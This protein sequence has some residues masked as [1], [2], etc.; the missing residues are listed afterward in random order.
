ME[1]NETYKKVCETVE[2]FGLHI[3]YDQ[4]DEKGW[5]RVQSKDWPDDFGGKNNCIILYKD[6][7][8]E[9]I[10]EELISSLINLGKN[11]KAKEFR[12]LLNI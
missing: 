2:V 12:K 5:I 11:L 7:G 4:W 1:P 3:D 10:K 8:F 9:T 6:D